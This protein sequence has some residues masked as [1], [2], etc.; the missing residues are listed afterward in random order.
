MLALFVTPVFALPVVD[1]PTSV[2]GGVQFQLSPRQG[3]QSDDV[4]AQQ[5]VIKMLQI[6]A[7][8]CT[9]AYPAPA[10][11]EECFDRVYHGLASNL[12]PH[13][14]YLNRKELDEFR[15][16][17][18]GELEGV[19]MQLG[20]IGKAGPFV[21][22]GIIPGGS[23]E[24]L[25]IRP[26]DKIVKINNQ[27]ASAFKDIA[28]AVKTIKGPA[29]TQV[30]LH[31]LRD[32]EGERA[33]TLTRRK[34]H[35]AQVVA[36]PLLKAN[37]KTFALIRLSLFGDTLNSEL[38]LAVE[39]ILNENRGK[40]QGFVFSVENN[41]GGRVD[42]VISALDLFMDFP[43]VSPVL[44]R[45]ASGITVYGED[46]SDVRGITRTRGD[47]TRGLPILVIVN[48]GSASASEIFA[49]TMKL[50][51]R[52]TIAGTEGT[53]QKGTMQS[54]Q[55]LGDGSA[56]KITIGEYLVG[57]KDNWVAVQCAGVAPDVLIPPLAQP[58]SEPNGSPTVKSER[59]TDCT[60]SGSVTSGGQMQ[61]P[62]Y[63]P[64]MKEAN[65]EHYKIATEEMLPLFIKW[66]DAEFARQQSFRR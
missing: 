13:S 50:Y 22:P 65:P 63:R 19:G 8:T 46:S 66:R 47:I 53:F 49:A 27:P 20:R 59:V 60:L 48:G 4:L 40:L 35:I 5:Y 17:G 30:T 62:P 61:N 37:G 25:G 23:A 45:T 1:A 24:E 32:G 2:L 28:D 18:R 21:I 6:V 39:K 58:L 55:S 26:G 56:L 43:S 64:S 52:A 9:E 3:A 34:I 38:K 29:G 44:V 31:I 36:E 12:D 11:V 10:N 57:T 33:Y 14:A 51:N 41:P 54:V 16:Q 42:Q 15:E 7:K